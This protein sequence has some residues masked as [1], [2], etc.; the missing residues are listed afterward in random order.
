MPYL[1]LTVELGSPKD[2]RTSAP[3]EPAASHRTA[4]YTTPPGSPLRSVISA[5]AAAVAA[6]VVTGLI[7]G[8]VG[9]FAAG[10]GTLAGGIAT[11]IGH[12]AFKA[13]KSKRLRRGS[14]APG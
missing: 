3:A 5:L 4:G 12:R 1:K 6:G 9:G 7:Q 2:S 14:P 10:L 11:L 13:R 8:L